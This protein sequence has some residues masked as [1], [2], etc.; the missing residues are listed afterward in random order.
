MIW[1]AVLETFS[2]LVPL[3]SVGHREE[4]RRKVDVRDGPLAG[5]AGAVGRHRKLPLVGIYVPNKLC[6]RRGGPQMSL[7]PRRFNS[8]PSPSNSTESNGLMEKADMRQ[9]C[10]ALA[11]YSKSALAESVD[12]NAESRTF[13]LSEMIGKSP[14]MMDLAKQI[15]RISPR[16]RTV[17]VTGQ[18]GTGKEMVARALHEASSLDPGP[19]V[20]CNCPAVV[21]TLFESELF[22]H[23]K[24]AFTGAF[25]DK[26][27]F[28]EQA[29]GG[30]LFLDEIGELPLF[31]QPK[32]L[33]MLQNQEIQVVGSVSTRKLNVRIIAATNRDL[34]SLMAR[35][36]FR[37][38]LYYRLSMVELAVPRLAQRQGDIPLLAEHFLNQFAAPSGRIISGLTPAAEGL[39][40]SYSW[41]GNIR[42]LE[43]AIAYGCIMAEHNVIDQQHLPQYLRNN[44]HSDDELPEDKE[45]VSLLPIAEI[46]RRHAI[47]V[48]ERVGRSKVKAAAVL[49]ISR[50]RLYRLLKA[51]KTDS[52]DSATDIE[53]E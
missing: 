10:I 40:K 45:E 15:Q 27:G 52:A 44:V 50:S 31:L 42:E 46:N 41:P 29:H 28:A 32:L 39:I 4:S 49:G 21:E 23:V 9:N 5:L 48:F 47:R 35:N 30:T 1:S 25:S 3:R 11:S 19:F 33:R 37:S 14:A 53:A 24:G 43:N 20:V 16:F 18:T 34:R 17:L 51:R 7:R 36:Q 38:D 2:T 26:I 22:G 13:A 8:L 12:K 6:C